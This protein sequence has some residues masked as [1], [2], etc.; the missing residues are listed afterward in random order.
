[1]SVSGVNGNQAAQ[2]NSSQD[3]G[4]TSTDSSLQS[5][6]STF[7]SLLVQELQNQDPT[8]PMD[9]TQ[10]VGQMISLNQLDQ[11]ASINQVVTNALGS[12]ATTA[13]SGTSGS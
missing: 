1:M 6:E 9:S 13:A 4:N 8:A 7:L 12:S 10:M 2:T 3:A 5:I 11:L